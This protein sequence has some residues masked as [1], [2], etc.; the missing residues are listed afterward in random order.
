M[1]IL[2]I[3]LPMAMKNWRETTLTN[4]V[5]VSSLSLLSRIPILFFYPMM[6]SALVLSLGLFLSPRSLLIISSL[7]FGYTHLFFTLPIIG[8]KKNLWIILGFVFGLFILG[9]SSFYQEALLI[10]LIAQAFHYQNQNLLIDSTYKSLLTKLWWFFAVVVHVGIVLCLH[11]NI[12]VSSF[13]VTAILIVFALIFYSLKSLNFE[14][15]LGILWLLLLVQISEK[16]TFLAAASAW[17]GMQYILLQ[18]DISSFWKPQVSFNKVLGLS[19]LYSVLITGL[20]LLQVSFLQSMV[21]I[22]ISLNLT[23]YIADLSLLPSLMKFRR[24]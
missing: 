11:F 5:N 6:A 21:V 22:V 15:G 1:S 17:H 24:S 12:K 9:V 14:K 13:D 3:P 10:L 16:E 2:T 19:V 7:F 8:L 23:H 20:Y 18:K 4:I